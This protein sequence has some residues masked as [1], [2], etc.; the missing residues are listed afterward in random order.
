MR[1][2]TRHPSL[3]V[4]V[5]ALLL[6]G[7]APVRSADKVEIKGFDRTM[8][9]G[10]YAWLMKPVGLTDTFCIATNLPSVLVS[11]QGTVGAG[12][13]AME[14]GAGNA[15]R[16]RVYFGA[17]PDGAR[18]AAPG[19]PMKIPVTTEKCAGAPDNVSVRV[20]IQP[21]DFNSAVSGSYADTL[22]VVVS[23]P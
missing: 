2:P 18:E 16:Y 10:R 19:V 23:A 11:L 7:A 15:M 6:F 20:D 21:D 9:F 17:L 1:R 8:S 14:D 5:A 22:T 13:F 3:A 12:L 4:S